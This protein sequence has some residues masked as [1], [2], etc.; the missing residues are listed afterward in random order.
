LLHDKLCLEIREEEFNEVI[1]FDPIK[2]SIILYKIKNSFN[3][4]KINF[5]N[6]LT[7][8]N[9]PTKEEIT[10]KVVDLL[11]N[12]SA[13]DYY[14]Y[15][16]E[17]KEKTRNIRYSL[18]ATQNDMD[19]HSIKSV[20]EKNI[21]SEENAV[22]E[23][24]NEKIDGNDKNT[25]N[26][27][28]LNI[29]INTNN[30]NLK[31]VYNNTMSNKGTTNNFN[32]TLNANKTFESNKEKE[33]QITYNTME[34]MEYNTGNSKRFLKPIQ[35]L[36]KF[37]ITNKTKTNL[38]PKSLPKL[39]INTNTEYKSS[40]MNSNIGTLSTY[41][42]FN[43]KLSL[44]SPP[45]DSLY[46]NENDF[47][48]DLGMLKIRELKDKMLKKQL[49]DMKKQEEI[50]NELKIKKINQYDIQDKYRLDF[51]NKINNPLYKFTKFTGINLFLHSDSKYNSS[52]SF[53]KLSSFL[54]GF[55]FPRFL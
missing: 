20:S 6:I 49:E 32:N 44:N 15:E 11:E 43:E 5:L 12:E 16:D 36:Y 51:V 52:S 39:K 50:K 38:T 28:N 8:T 29:N 45:I 40:I 54:F 22:E 14:E 26:Y 53:I 55:F 2:A 24:K 3:R 33:N 46:K 42:I 17:V 18:K 27:K 48:N 13:I 21:I 34:T 47:N 31:S 41:S 35:N 4:K 30:S 7:F 23:D 1:Q 19:L 25:T 10:N 9:P 37:K